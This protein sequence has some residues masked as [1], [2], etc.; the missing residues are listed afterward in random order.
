MFFG[1]FLALFIFLALRKRD[2][3]GFKMRAVEAKSKGLE[4]E[5]NKLWL[6][7][8]AFLDFITATLHYVA[9]NFISGS[10]YQM[11]RGGSIVT[12]LI[13]SIIFLKSKVTRNQL[14]GSALVLIGVFIV[15]LS[16]MI[17]K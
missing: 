5:F 7:V 4:I 3:E 16:N 9:L 11:M 1:E 8:P 14:A 10:V 13:F 17:F 6:A 12:T 15:G 2:P